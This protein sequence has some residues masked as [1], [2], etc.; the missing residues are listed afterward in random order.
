MTQ[1][2]K[3]VVLENY[4]FE[5]T[6]NYFYQKFFAILGLPRFGRKEAINEF[7]QKS[8]ARK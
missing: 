4:H 2:H 1:K 6:L 7:Y 8:S 3:L 5:E